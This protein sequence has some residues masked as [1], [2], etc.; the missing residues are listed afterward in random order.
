[1]SSLMQHIQDVQNNLKKSG[2]YP[3]EQAISQGIVVRLL[4]ALGWDP[5]NLQMVF[6]EY[7]VR[8]GRVDFA[9][10]VEKKLPLVFIEVKQ[11]KSIFGADEQVFKYAYHQGVPLVIVTDGTKWHFYLPTAPGNYD[12]RRFYVLDLVERDADESA[13][14]LKRYLSHK[15]IADESAFE[16]ARVDHRAATNERK[17]REAIPDAWQKLLEEKNEAL[18]GIISQKVESLCEHTPSNGHVIN[19]LHTLNATYSDFPSA[20][21]KRTDSP[22]QVKQTVANV[23]QS[24]RASPQKLKVTFPDGTV[25]CEQKVVST[26]IETLRKIGFDR[27]ETLNISVAGRPL[28]T[29]QKSSNMARRWKDVGSGYYVHVNSSTDAKIKL[30]NTINNQLNVRIKIK[31]VAAQ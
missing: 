28:I 14:R 19:Y 30:L 6:P 10:L 4:T 15:N 12:Q 2:H 13:A 24:D 23:S 27:V 7:P 3:N 25:I 16:H 9:L 20:R 11:P 17:T 18:I 8:G 1:M 21:K 29:Q 5:Y 26:M 22:T 31:K